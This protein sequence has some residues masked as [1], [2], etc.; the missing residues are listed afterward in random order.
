MDLNDVLRDLDWD[1]SN[2]ALPIANA[3][4]KILEDAVTS[5]TS[6]RNRLQTDLEE[7]RSK[8]S[9]LQ[10]HVKNVRD[11]LMVTQVISILN[12]YYFIKFV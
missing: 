5:K 6:E 10:D 11:E 12:N 7:N 1:V 3:E 8:V 9:A 4:N 2:I